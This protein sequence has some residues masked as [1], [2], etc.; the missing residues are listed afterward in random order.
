LFLE[1]RDE[2]LEPV[3]LDLVR[4]LK[5]VLQD[6]QN[7]VLDRLRQGRG[8]GTALDAL[9]AAPDQ[10]GRYRD[11][12]V[13]PLA[14]AARAGADLLGL[15]LSD[16]LPTRAWASE[17]GDEMVAGLRERVTRSLEGGAD[18]DPGDTLGAVYRQW[19]TER[20]EQIAHHH[21]MAAFNKGA[22]AGAAG[23]TPLRWV[24]ADAGPCPDCDDNALAGPTP[25]GEPFPTG[26]L[27][28]PAHAGCGCV[29]AL[30]ADE[31]R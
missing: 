2:C 3:A 12:A 16:G 30:A 19:K 9:P 18:A 20:V 13:D 26:Q 25:K 29:L 8:R 11:A 28:P 23:G 7:E 31:A 27:H 1:R 21:L 6:E 24:F 4:R 5:R 15:G 22:Y 17:L 10:A 14:T